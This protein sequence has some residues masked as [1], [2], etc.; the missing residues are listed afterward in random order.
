MGYV[1]SRLVYQLAI[2]E[3]TLLGV[4][5]RRSLGLLAVLFGAGMVRLLEYSMAFGMV[6]HLVP[7]L[8]TELV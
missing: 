3:V 5:V 1:G 2:F 6:I 7:S 4:R 8:E